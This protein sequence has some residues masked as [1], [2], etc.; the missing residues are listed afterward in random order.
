[1]TLSHSRNSLLDSVR[2]PK[3]FSLV[4]LL[5]ALGVI[6]ILMAIALPAVQISRAAARTAQCRNQIRQL[7]I[8]AMN[9]ESNYGVYPTRRFFREIAP[10][11]EISADARGSLHFACPDDLQHANGQDN[12]GRT[13]YAI[14]AGLGSENSQHVGVVSSVKRYVR[15]AEVTDGLSNTA[16]IGEKLSF[17]W[18]AP[19]VVDWKDLPHD[20]D[21]TFWYFE[22][23]PQSPDEFRSLCRQETNGSVTTW[24]V[25]D[26]YHHLMPPNSRSCVSVNG[27]NLTPGPQFGFGVMAASRH[28]GGALVA[29][30]DGSAR[31]VNNEVATEIWSAIGTRSGHETVSY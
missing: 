26:V 11:M 1:M 14:N 5:V 29:F 18:Y 15:A 25:T 16:M 28:P 27:G 13:S 17:P 3:G 8:A 9:Y 19:Q 22:G 31:L 24:F 6:A 7:N 23:H 4:E 10:Y 30:A 21:R 2:A 20:R 12:Q